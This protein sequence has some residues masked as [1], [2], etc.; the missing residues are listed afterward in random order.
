MCLQ[1][2]ISFDTENA[3]SSGVWFSPHKPSIFKIL[4]VAVGEL[5]TVVFVGEVVLNHT[6]Q[7]AG[8][9][10]EKSVL[11]LA[12]HQRGGR[13]LRKQPNEAVRNSGIRDRAFHLGRDID[14]LLLL[15]CL[16]RQSF[17][18]RFHD[19]RVA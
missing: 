4:P 11:K 6:S 7:K 13:M 3:S 17:Q 2:E 16:E 14:Q 1:R 15:G 8:D 5:R 12:D 9:I 19:S 10:I 18:F